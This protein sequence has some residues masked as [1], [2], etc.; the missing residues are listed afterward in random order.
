MVVWLQLK[1]VGASSNRI[2]D[3]LDWGDRLQISETLEG[4]ALTLPRAAH[5]FVAAHTRS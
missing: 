5:F 2:T 3:R 1:T 4:A